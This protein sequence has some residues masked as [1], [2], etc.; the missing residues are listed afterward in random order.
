MIHSASPQSRPG[1]DRRL[2]LKFWDGRTDGRTL[3]VKI[4]MTTGRNCGWS[5]GSIA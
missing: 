2:I 5:R 4:V 1:S 3:C